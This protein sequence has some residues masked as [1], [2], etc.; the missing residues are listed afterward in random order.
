MYNLIDFSCYAKRCVL[1]IERQLIFTNDTVACL[2]SDDKSLILYY[3]T[4]RYMHFCTYEFTLYKMM[5]RALIV[6]VF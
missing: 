3:V 4:L 1:K 5:H 6:S 2:V